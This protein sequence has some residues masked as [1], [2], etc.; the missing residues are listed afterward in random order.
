MFFHI[1]HLELALVRLI[2]ALDQ[3][4]MHHPLGRRHRRPEEHRKVLVAQERHHQRRRHDGK[5]EYDHQRPGDL[6][7]EFH[8]KRRFGWPQNSQV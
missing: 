6:R 2:L 8:V 1:P 7:F 5:A 4:V 3:Y